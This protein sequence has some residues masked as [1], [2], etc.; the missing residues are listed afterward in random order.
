[1]NI[2]LENLLEN[3]IIKC[4]NELDTLSKSLNNAYISHNEV[5]LLKEEMKLINLMKN[6][7][8]IA[9]L[10]EDLLN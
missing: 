10:R 1:M 8:K 5:L 7:D 6:I 3:D 2:I 4:Y 9:N